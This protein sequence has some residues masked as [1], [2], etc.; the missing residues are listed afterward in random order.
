MDDLDLILDVAVFRDAPHGGCFVYLREL[1]DRLPAAGVNP[2][3]YP[4]GILPFRD[5][6]LPVRL[7]GG[8][9]AA[10]RPG[11]RPLR[12]AL[13]SVLR[14]GKRTMER[15]Y[16]ETA[17]QGRRHVVYHSVYHQR[18]PVRRAATVAT[19]HDMIFERFPQFFGAYWDLER[20]RK[21]TVARASARCI[22]I[23][24]RTK[25]DLCERLRLAP[26]KVDVVYHGVNTS[27]FDPVSTD[28]DR[29]WLESAG[30]PS[31]GYLLY[32]GGRDNHKNFR[33]WLRAYTSSRLRDLPLVVA[34]A[35]WSRDEEEDLRVEGARGVLLVRNP[36]DRELVAL[37]RHAAAF[38]CP[39]L[40]EGFGL[41]V[42][43]AMACGAPVAL[44]NAGSLPEVGGDVAEYFDPESGDSMVEAVTAL[45]SPSVAAERRRRGIERARTFSWDRTIA[46][47][48]ESYRR[49]G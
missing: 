10:G 3:Y 47:T 15:L 18:F 16:W 26:E 41:P 14:R 19:I 12:P 44:S 46:G 23:S 2:Q 24:E 35:A 38:V 48:V 28:R 8:G 36:R 45:L 39:S 33:A 40:Y 1:V 49:A 30:V 9:S 17:C 32:V 21:A 6:H 42:L 27:V 11:R 29:R 31:G 4:R 13:R 5:P 7:D 22:A 25:A 20:S 37:Y 34:G 43:E